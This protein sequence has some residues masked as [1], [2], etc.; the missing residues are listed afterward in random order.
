MFVD[1]GFWISSCLTD[2]TVSTLQEHYLIN[3]GTKIGVV[4][5]RGEIFFLCV[6]VEK[7]NKLKETKI[8]I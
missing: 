2:I 4:S 7:K 6:A 1:V 5:I 8:V 3:L